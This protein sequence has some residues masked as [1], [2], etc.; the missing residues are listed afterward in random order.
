MK[1]S[2]ADKKIHVLMCTRTPF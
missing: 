1:G 2:G